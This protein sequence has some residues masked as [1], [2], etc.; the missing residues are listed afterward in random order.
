VLTFQAAQQQGY[1]FWGIPDRPFFSK[2]EMHLLP[3]LGKEGLRTIK[4]KPERQQMQVPR[5]S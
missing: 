2:V 1:L 4:T 3:R 5:R